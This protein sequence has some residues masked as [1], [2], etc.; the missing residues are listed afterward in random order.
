MLLSAHSSD[1]A[2]QGAAV[3]GGDQVGL[4]VAGGAGDLLHGVDPAAVLLVPGQARVGGPGHAG[5]LGGGGGGVFPVAGDGPHLGGR[6]VVGGADAA[7]ALEGVGLELGLAGGAKGGLAVLALGNEALGE[8]AAFI[9]RRRGGAAVVA[10]DEGQREDRR[11]EQPLT[12]RVSPSSRIR[13]ACST[14]CSRD[15]RSGITPGGGGKN[16]SELAVAKQSERATGPASAAERR[17]NQPD[18]LP[19]SAADAFG[20]KG[21]RLGAGRCGADVRATPAPMRAA[22]AVASGGYSGFAFQPA[23]ASSTWSWSFQTF[24]GPRTPL[25][26]MLKT[27]GVPSPRST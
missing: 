27:A 9:G 6:G 18:S 3:G 21:L 26:R 15:Q 17:G 20:F 25:A 10:A 19:F 11:Q 1:G 13:G 16:A 2:G 12:H 22:T 23:R 7:G 24:Q 8:V 14:A 5:L 4:V